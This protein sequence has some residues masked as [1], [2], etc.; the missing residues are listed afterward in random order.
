[1]RIRRLIR[2]SG[3]AALGVTAGGLG[4]LT[5]VSAVSSAAVNAAG[6]QRVTVI[7]KEYSFKLSTSTVHVGTVTFTV[8]NK[9]KLAHDFYIFG[10]ATKVI[11]PG[12]S[13][14]L[15]VKFT[16]AGN[17]KYRSTIPGQAGKGMKGVLGVGVAPA[18]LTGATSPTM[19]MVA[20]IPGAGS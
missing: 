4:V 17:F 13:A 5:A 20:P 11:R 3:L 9:G 18:T 19:R 15:R 2:V 12:K 14:M 8:E 10:G 6:P 7:A 16:H 1:M